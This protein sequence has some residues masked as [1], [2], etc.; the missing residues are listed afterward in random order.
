MRNNSV[1][2]TDSGINPITGGG[3]VGIHY[4]DALKKVSDLNY[5][6]CNTKLPD[7]KYNGVPAFTLNAEDWGY[8]KKH[9]NSGWKTSPFFLDYMAFH[10]L[11]KTPTDLA[12]TYGCP[13]GLTVE[14]L[15]REFDTKIVC[16]LAPHIINITE[17]EH[18]KFIGEYN[19][20]HLNNDVLW[21]LYSRHLKFADVVVVHSNKSAEYIEKKAN[22]T[23]TPMVIPHGCTPPENIPDYPNVF[24][25]GYF[26]AIG[27]DKGTTYLANA[28]LQLPYQDSKMIIGGRES[29]IF[30]LPEPHMSRFNIIGYV[31]KLEDFYKHI[32]VY[33]QAC[34]SDDTRLMT[35]QGLKSIDEV[36]IGDKVWTLDKD[37]NL[38]LNRIN[39]VYL[40]RYDGMMV[41]IEN[42][43]I[44][45]LVTPNH[46]VYY[47]SQK[48]K[49]KLKVREARELFDNNIRIHIPTTGKWDIEFF[50]T[51][52][53]IYGFYADT[54][55][56]TINFDEIKGQNGKAKNMIKNIEIKTFLELLGYFIAEG[57][58]TGKNKQ[59]VSISVCDKNKQ[60]HIVELFK[61]V[62]LNPII[63]KNNINCHS[64]QLCEILKECGQ[65]AK[66]KKIPKQYLNFNR[67]NLIYLYKGMMAGDGSRKGHHVLYYTSSD[68]LKDNFIELCLKLGFSTKTWKRKTKKHIIKKTGQEIGEFENWMIS[69]REKHNKGTVKTI[70]HVSLEE[71][72]GK[73]WCVETKNKNLLV[74]RNGLISFSGNSITEGFGITPL[75]AM[76][77]GRPVIVA[78]GAG[79]SE[80]VTDGQ[81]GFVVPIRDIDAIKNKITYFYDNPDEIKRMG[82]EARKTAMK[83]NWDLIK[84][85]YIDIFEELL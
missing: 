45:Q 26:G 83:Y 54:T 7:F 82:D 36:K 25:P 67:K 20:P 85:E 48:N 30:S 3:K 24:T 51:I 4:I 38:E 62:G 10:L 74:E 70:E 78:D 46:R 49:S 14:E 43:Q 53:N 42:K 16:D 68:E 17:S 65:G 1:F 81:D 39:K 12:M 19:Y 28:W 59:Y 13:F 71:Y 41:K 2:I 61:K 60:K 27:I 72:H 34:Y 40:D 33:V 23:K 79:M 37:S 15:K 44:N 75:E 29:S 58:V 50:S 84:K 64:L 22:L 55:K 73:V 57:C 66:N 77:Y 8:R 6:L 31:E 18:M 47:Y 76:A 52:G 35:E 32:S 5:I 56:G 80:L 63:D 11:K 9:D 21:G 69:I